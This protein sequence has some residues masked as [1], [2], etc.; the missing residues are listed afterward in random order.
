[1][2]NEIVNKQ[3][4]LKTILDVANYL[5]DCKERYNNLFRQEEIKNKDLPYN[6]K[7]YEYANGN[8]KMNY[9]I[10]FYN[11]QTKT[12]SD[13]NWFIGNIRETKLIKNIRL[14][15]YIGFATRTQGSDYND[16]INSIDIYV[17]F[18]DHYMTD[19]ASRV[20]ISIDTKNQERESNNI[21]GTILNM[22]ENNEERYNKTIKYRKARMQS[23]CISIGIIL[24]YILYIILK[25]NIAKLPEFIDTYMSN[26]YV[27]IFGQ[28]FVSILLGNIFAYWYILSVY[29][30]L[31]PSTKYV[32]YNSSTYKSVYA[33]DIDTYLD[34][35][36]VHFGKY[37]DAEKRRNKIEKIYKITRI[38]LLIQLVI[39]AILFLTLK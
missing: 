5:E 10:E 32:G 7:K 18:R 4:S 9:T 2:E 30:P 37:W 20:T 33:D 15:L 24:S 13:Y 25:I 16:I 1:M 35:S 19:E 36:E 23:L 29:K 39:S 11:G 14:N 27:L 38:I 22:L 21:Y 12:E 6:Q 26:K 8:I 28:W 34:G 17:D 3:I 31:L